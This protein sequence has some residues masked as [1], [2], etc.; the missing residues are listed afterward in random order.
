MSMGSWKSTLEDMATELQ[1]C[2]R[3]AMRAWQLSWPAPLSIPWTSLEALYRSSMSWLPSLP[4]SRAAYLDVLAALNLAGAGGH[5]LRTAALTVAELSRAG[6]VARAQGFDM[7][8]P[9]HL[10]EAEATQARALPWWRAAG[11]A[12]LEAAIHTCRALWLVAIFVPV[13]LSA[14]LALVWNLY[15]A[16]WMELLRRTLEAGGPAFIKWGQW[17]ATRHDLFP[18]DMCSELEHLHTQAPAHKFHHT[19]RAIEAAFGMPHSE[20]FDSIEERPVASGSIGQIH[21]ARLSEKGA[22][23]TGFEAG[24]LVAVKVRHPGVAD[25]ILRDFATM[26]A[27]AGVVGRLEALQHLRLEDTLKQFAAP[28][29]EQVDLAREA[30]NLQRFNFNFRN[31][32]AVQFP[33]P[34]YP[35]VSSEVL[36]ESYE[37]G[38][39]ITRYISGDRAGGGPQGLREKL[40]DIGAGTMLQMM[41]MD[42]LIHSDLHPGNILVR[43]APPSGGL[44]GALYSVLD[45]LKLASPAMP[46]ST[47]ARID[48]LQRRWLQPQM[49]L[50]DVGMATELSGEDQRNMIGLFQSFAA[51]DGR[52]CG[53]WTLRF[54]GPGQQCP[55]PEAFKSA[56]EATFN[57]LRRLDEG[58]D[59]SDTAFK[60]GADTLGHILELVRQYKVSLPG[61]I[62][63]VVVTTLVL[64][65]WSNK[66]DPNHSV[67][68]KVQQMFEATSLPWR[69]RLMSTV[70][71]LM[72]EEGQ[73]ALLMA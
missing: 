47:R 7:Y 30:A 10:A 71:H 54:S 21:R 42:N 56:I 13:A 32:P 50:L 65:G 69:Q 64:E 43:L 52:A 44:V 2:Q 4:G 27:V 53:E 62:C 72:A 45:E 20:L 58:A 15:R 48:V 29:K 18:P 9:N 59:W 63:A 40:S 26:V 73:G 28:L 19:Q 14:P 31:T 38:D 37:E 24:Q 39:H 22:A 17:A 57:E 67:L 68:T 34:L 3:A 33:V 25:T 1:S 41:L 11:A 36:V 66:L 49:V 46:A 6:A 23:L 61:H 55:D 51:M 16:E 60:N 8:L 35:L 5:L 12:V 70:D